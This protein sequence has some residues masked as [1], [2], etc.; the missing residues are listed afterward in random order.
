MEPG[1]YKI[2]VTY[3]DSEISAKYDININGKPVAGEFLL[4]N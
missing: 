4:E 3:G 1:F 2:V